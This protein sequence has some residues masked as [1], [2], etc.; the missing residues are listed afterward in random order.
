MGQRYTVVWILVLGLSPLVILAVL[1]FLSVG[2]DVIDKAP[3]GHDED[4][5]GSKDA[6]IAEP[7][8]LD[9]WVVSGEQSF[10]PKCEAD[11]TDTEDEPNNTCGASQ[12]IHHLCPNSST[13]DIRVAKATNRRS[14]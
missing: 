6:E 13:V 11:Q 9:E 4:N 2:L 7:R 8:I 1:Q 3:H 10:S 5:A 12:S 14:R